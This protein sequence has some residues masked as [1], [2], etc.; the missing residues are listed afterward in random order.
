MET[1]EGT[2]TENLR[3]ELTDEEIRE[4]A[5]L[6]ARK[7]H[8]RDQLEDARSTQNKAM[9]ADVEDLEVEV[10]R[11]LGEIS[12]TIG[13]PRRAGDRCPGL[14]QRD[15]AHGAPGHERR[16]AGADAGRNSNLT[17]SPRESARISIASPARMTSGKRG[18]KMNTVFAA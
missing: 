10:R 17:Y 3:C 16:G 13:L 11:L 18:R 9:K 14:R 15:D 12:S 2:R 1:E 8:D 4:R 6:A 5:D 7:A